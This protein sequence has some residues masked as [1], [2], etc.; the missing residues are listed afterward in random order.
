[1]SGSSPLSNS[2]NF[3]TELAKE[4]N[5]MAANR[6]LLAWIRVSIALIGIGFGVNDIVLRLWSGNDENH[7]LMKF[8]RLFSLSMIALGVFSVSV[9]AL[10]YRAEIKRL[11][12]S[13][14]AYTPRFPL[15]LM[16]AGMLVII[17]LG[18]LIFIQKLNSF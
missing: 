13:D 4:R 5:H 11:R 3:Q 14:Y 16:V 8:T 18:A 7:Y 1:M 2:P 10:D 6:T 12:Q 15:G 17:S 9:S